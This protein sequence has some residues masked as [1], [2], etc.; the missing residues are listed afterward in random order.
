MCKENKLKIN[1][2]LKNK[3]VN[4]GRMNKLNYSPTE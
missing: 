2:N 1:K 4:K 3:Q